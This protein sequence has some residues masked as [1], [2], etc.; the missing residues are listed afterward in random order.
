[1]A[2]QGKRLR[3]AYEAVDRERLYTLTAA[4]ETLKSQPAVKFDQMVDVAI[5]LNVDARKA[6]QAMRGVFA[7]P[8]GNGKK[9]RV[10]VFARGAKADEAKAAGAD[11]VGA[12][13]LIEKI[14]GGA[15]DFDRCVATPDMMAL[16]GKVAKVL[17]PRGLMPNPKLGTVT[18][19]VA[20]AV[21]AA[22]GG[23]I[24]YRTD[25]TGIIHAGVGRLSFKAGDLE[26]NIQAF[27]SAISKGRPAGVKGS[28]IK[29]IALS[30]TM[31]P[32]LKLDIASAIKS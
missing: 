18:L 5:N 7:L 29:K 11:I 10:A 32:G 6:D 14:G 31:G 2:K 17:G 24:E 19:D 13:D 22:K 20:T 23:Q 4:I 16:L 30:T 21:K 1:M 3:K 28:F 12:E 15:L 27:V 26:E 8:H 25:K 9:V